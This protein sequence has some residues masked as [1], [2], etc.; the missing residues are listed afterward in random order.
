MSKSKAEA[1]NEGAAEIYTRLI[2]ILYTEIII[3]LLMG[4]KLHSDCP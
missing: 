2:F 1:R 3:K 4:L